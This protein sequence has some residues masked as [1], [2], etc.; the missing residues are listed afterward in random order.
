MAGGIDGKTDWKTDQQTDR[1]IRIL[2]ESRIKQ[3][4]ENAVKDEMRCECR[5][6]FFHLDKNVMQ[7]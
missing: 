1:Q 3:L 2:V 7:R 5:K 4:A 6:L